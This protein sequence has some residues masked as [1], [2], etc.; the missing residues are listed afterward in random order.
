MRKINLIALFAAIVASGCET[1]GDGYLTHSD[2]RLTGSERA[3]VQA[4]MDSYFKAPVSLSNLKATY[5]LS[6]GSIPVCGYVTAQVGGKTSPPALFAG[7][8]S[9][10]GFSPL[11]IPGKG[12]D[13]QRI[14]TVRAF[15]SAE[16]ISI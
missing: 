12:Q 1:T 4:G 6:D 14:A 9:G 3:A 10:S 2:H 15:C 5:R 13:P 16:Q 11:R 7:T 8:L